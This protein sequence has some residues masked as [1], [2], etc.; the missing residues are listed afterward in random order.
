MTTSEAERRAMQRA[1]QLAVTPGVVAIAS[2]RRMALRSASLVAISASG[3][4]GWTPGGV[5]AAGAP[6]ADRAWRVTVS[7]HFSSGL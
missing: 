1:L 5:A 6:P 2:A 3:S 7:V 4:C